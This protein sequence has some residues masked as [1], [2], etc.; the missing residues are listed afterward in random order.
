M[1]AQRAPRHIHEE[2]ERPTV[3]HIRD[4]VAKD[5]SYEENDR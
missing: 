5:I 2:Q 4:L 1:S 3:R